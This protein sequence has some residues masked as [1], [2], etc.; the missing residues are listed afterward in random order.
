MRGKLG[1]VGTRG[2]VVVSK[3]QNVKP[4]AGDLER[5][6]VYIIRDCDVLGPYTKKR[7]EELLNH[8][9]IEPND[10]VKIGTDGR[11]FPAAFLVNE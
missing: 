9:S 2:G 1:Q 4:C 8:G 11:A 3:R 5:T 7:A 6:G 10:L